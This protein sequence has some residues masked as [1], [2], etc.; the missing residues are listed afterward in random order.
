MKLNVRPVAAAAATTFAFFVASELDSEISSSEA[1]DPL[2]SP[3]LSA[4]AL[5]P[6]WLREIAAYKELLVCVE[7]TT[8]TS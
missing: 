3:L 5:K 7:R 4:S 6:S 2:S 8:A 1:F